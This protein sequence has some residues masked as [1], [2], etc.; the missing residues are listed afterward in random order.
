LNWWKSSAALC[1]VLA[2]AGCSPIRTARVQ[3]PALQRPLQRQIRNAADAGE[4]DYQAKAL[5]A[6]LDADPTNL[7]ARLELARHYQS[8]GFPEIAIEH[9]R[10]AVERA[11][12]SPAAAVELAK[13]LRAEGHLDQAVQ[14]LS[15]FV[16]LHQP[17]TEVWA[18]LGL[19]RDETGDWKG[20]E[21]A[22]RAAL[23]LSP[24]RD[25]LLNNLGWCL[26]RQG[27]NGEA[28]EEFRAALRLNP[29][30]VVARNN[31]GTSLADT[32]REAV[33][34]LQ[35]VA[36]P[37]SAHNNLAVALMEAGNYPAARHEIEIALGYN[38][39][40]AAALNNL[41]MLSA[42]DGKPAEIAAENQAAALPA[43]R[44]PRVLQA[45]RHLFW[46]SGSPDVRER[47]NSGSTVAS[48]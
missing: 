29:R 4:G 23:A 8:K 17:D 10:L 19:L 24:S 38:R 48:R 15:A 41:R 20:G 11:P 47:K 13:L 44:W 6:R 33:A 32:P 25:D 18:W 46:K 3:Q 43:S 26:L 35:S 40:N 39:Q 22:H 30:S 14:G 7:A 5:R 12:E 42:L 37:A 45:W 9:L 34:H 36:D 27:R 16:T 2:L 21:Q 1:G 31:L 28:A